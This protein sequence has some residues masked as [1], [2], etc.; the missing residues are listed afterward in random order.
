MRQKR[1][2]VNRMAVSRLFCILALNLLIVLTNFCSASAFEITP[3]MLEK[4]DARIINPKSALEYTFRCGVYAAQKQFEKALSDCNKA[5][6]MD[7]SL[8]EAYFTK[9]IIY[10]EI[11]E[12][13]KAVSELTNAMEINKKILKQRISIEE[14][15]QEIGKITLNLLFRGFAHYRIYENNNMQSELDKAFNDYDELLDLKPSDVNVLSS[16]YHYRCLAYMAKFHASPS[17][18]LLNEALND[19]N[20]AIAL[21]PE[22]PKFYENRAKVYQAKNDAVKAF[23]DI[24]R[25]EEL[26]KRKNQ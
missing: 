21:V 6:E 18:E 24:N 22:N 11:Q 20:K 8:S 4:M 7:N 26:K 13:Y 19:I 5:V 16:G 9:G 12:Y 2:I 3:E 15:R 14:R 25:S 10:F 17:Q 23:S 1:E